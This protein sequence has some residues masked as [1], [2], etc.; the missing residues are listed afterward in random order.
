MSNDTLK[1]SYGFE[2][3]ITLFNT[4]KAKSLFDGIILS[5]NS[6]IK[7]ND[8]QNAGSFY[9]DCFVNTQFSNS[10]KRVFIIEVIKMI[11]EDP[12]SFDKHCQF[13]IAFVGEKFLNCIENYSNTGYL[14]NF[15]TFSFRF[16]CEY[17]ICAKNWISDDFDN[18]FNLIVRK[19]EAFSESRNI[20]Y[21]LRSMPIAISRKVLSANV[22]DKVIG[23]DEVVNNARLLNDEITK[24]K[25]SWDDEFNAR[26][27]RIDAMM[28]KLDDIE[29]GYNFVGLSKGFS[30]LEKSKKIE[31]K[32]AKNKAYFWQFFSM[33]VPVVSIY[34]VLNRVSNE[35]S[36]NWLVFIPF[37]SFI[38]ISLMFYRVALI[39]TKSIKS[40]LIQ[41]ELRQALCQFIQK[42][43]E[44][45]SELKGQN[46]HTLQKFEDL[47]FSG[48]V[49]N[50]EQIPSTFDGMDQ[51]HK[52]LQSLSR[53]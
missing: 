52:L 12:Y 44:Y 20:E 17:K 24:E 10:F 29:T 36:L 45:S 6:F 53:K 7:D 21:A 41:L 25:Q 23:V 22:I 38:M 19:P 31:L 43:A 46:G 18:W 40:Q 27:K 14:S 30:S 4:K 16:L 42:Y 9:S 26:D 8:S 11:S 35:T 39:E 51:L 33:S 1:D 37:L 13:N 47:I 32:N 3:N 5:D 28:K 50:E 2:H 48:I 15:F 34:T 49:M